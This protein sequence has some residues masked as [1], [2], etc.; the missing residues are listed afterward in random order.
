MAMCSPLA[1]LRIT[2]NREMKKALFAPQPSSTE[3]FR[4]EETP[5]QFLKR[6]KFARDHGSFPQ[7]HRLKSALTRRGFVVQ[8]VE[9]FEPNS[10]W[11][12][13]LRPGKVANGREPRVIR[14]EIVEALRA[15][16]QRCRMCD[17]AAMSRGE[18][19]TA[20]FI[21]NARG[22][23]GRL[24]FSDSDWKHVKFYKDWSYEDE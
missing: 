16:G 10:V 8:Q 2:S 12:V 5:L 6:H 19:L 20:A 7:H 9:R 14:R 18:R 22:N 15:L 11:S 23:P 24:L 13:V 4:S 21:W 3:V 1:H 17:V